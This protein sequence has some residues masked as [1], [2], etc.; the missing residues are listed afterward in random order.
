M[1]KEYDRSLFR[2]KHQLM[3][4]IFHKIY[5]NPAKLTRDPAGESYALNLRKSSVFDYEELCPFIEISTVISGLLKPLIL[6]QGKHDR[7]N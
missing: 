7:I 5:Y 6:V 3:K 4:Q 2:L 1:S